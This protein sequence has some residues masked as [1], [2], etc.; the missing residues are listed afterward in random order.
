VAD[1]DAGDVGNRVVLAWRAFEWDAKVT[2]PRLRLG[3][4]WR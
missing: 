2:R 3:E 1:F 4:K